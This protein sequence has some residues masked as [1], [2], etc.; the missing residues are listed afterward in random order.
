[1]MQYDVKAA[2]ITQS[3]WMLPNGSAYRTRIKQITY[4]PTGSQSGGL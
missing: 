3:G 2:K 1:M 4:V